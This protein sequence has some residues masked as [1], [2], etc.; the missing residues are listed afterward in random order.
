MMF[1]SL[2]KANATIRLFLMT[3]WF[4][5]ALTSGGEFHV[6]PT[7]SN[8]AS[9]S[10]SA[11]WLTIQHA[12]DSTG[13]GDVV[14]VHTGIYEEKVRF[15]AT[16]GTSAHPLIIEAAD[17][18][19]PVIDGTNLS[20]TFSATALVEFYQASDIVFRGFELRNFRT[21]SQSQTPS[22]I[23][24]SGDCVGLTIENNRIHDIETLHANG[25][26]HGI[27]C[28]GDTEGGISELTIRGNELYDLV[29][30]S[31]EAM[32]LNGNVFDFTVSENHVHHCNNIGIDL[33]G[34]E[35][36]FDD[37][38]L[39]PTM[40]RAR[41]GVVSDNL[42]HHIDTVTNP[43]YGGDRSAAGIY[44]DG[45]ADIVIE[46]NQIHRCNIGVE[47]AS[48]HSGKAASRIHVREN[49]IWLNHIGGIYT[50][51]YN[52][53]KGFVEDCRFTHNTLW[54]NDSDLTDTGEILLQHDV[55]TSVFEHNIVVSNAQA[56]MVA[57]PFLANTGNAFDYNFYGYPS[58]QPG[59][60]FSWK[61]VD[62]DPGDDLPNELDGGDL[63]I[64]GLESTAG[65]VDP[66][67]AEN[68]RLNSGA[69]PIDRG[70]PAFVIGSGELDA[71]GNNRVVH[72]RVDLGAYEFGS[73]PP[74]IPSDLS[75][76]PATPQSSAPLTWIL[77][78]SDHTGF[79]LQRALGSSG[80]F[81]TLA[82]LAPEDRAYE[83]EAVYPGQ[84]YRYRIRAIRDDVPSP[85]SNE[86]SVTIAAPTAVGS[87]ATIQGGFS[88]ADPG[89][90]FRG[91]LSFRIDNRLRMTGTFVMGSFRRTVTGRFDGTGHLELPPLVRTGLDP[92]EISLD[93]DFDSDDL[94]LTGTVMAGADRAALEGGAVARIPN[95]FA[96][97]Y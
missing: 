90:D 58:G 69:Y 23:F 16:G 46:R 31:S 77:G 86:A 43:A 38:L 12:V 20:P 50:G 94:P 93:L 10:S 24:M 36:T 72:S 65:L 55:R 37:P 85:F 49:V 47:V 40:D 71:D 91:L 59:A 83:D 52:T 81:E 61:K 62:Y 35:G 89:S 64:T 13:A 66:S 39:G 79:E 44:V 2:T 7:G 33:I 3:A 96:G 63:F 4:G 22:A 80:A 41:N 75:V 1:E 9:G 60:R 97:L 78:V 18:E 92:V 53:N 76:T 27:A 73:T 19:S 84:F 14:K 30:G 25:N 26:A 51:G 21:T 82:N 68:F 54:K 8:S 42:V 45:G 88:P 32:V 15:I 95:P 17:G 34:Y 6:S 56:L 48:E 87:G 5:C 29:L 70:D 67:G 28:Y 74:S 57:N 11:P